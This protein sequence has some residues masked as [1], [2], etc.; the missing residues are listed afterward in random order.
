MNAKRSLQALLW[1][2]TATTTVGLA[3]CSRT[4]EE[5]KP[6]PSVTPDAS[7]PKT[8]DSAALPTEWTCPQ[9]VSGAKMILIPWPDGS[10]YCI[11]EREA[12]YAEY[13][14]FL[15]A[16]GE[17][18]S[19]QPPECAWNDSFVPGWDDPAHEIP[20]CSVWLIDTEPDRAANCLDFCDA[21]AFCAWTGKRLCS[22]RGADPGKVTMVGVTEIEQA[23][24]TLKSEWFN[25]CTQGG[26]TK[27]PYADAYEP[28][29]C[30]DQAKIDVEGED[31]A[32][33]VRGAASNTCHGTDAPYDGVY[34]MSGSVMQWLNICYP[35]KCVIQGGRWHM[36]A[37]S[38]DSNYGLA[39][40]N[41]ISTVAGVRCCADAVPKTDSNP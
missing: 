21:W 34:N 11:D 38:C 31:N 6:D 39:S 23:A 26:A 4:D 37:L 41:S 25:V 24:P 3:G 10:A 30:I 19:G 12:V 16:K 28:G 15:D 20:Q 14:Q 32:L 22:V 35:G 5:V 1:A 29:R 18:F 17:D 40:I 33:A 36:E 13:K 2:A 8:Q 9:G 7:D 27:Y